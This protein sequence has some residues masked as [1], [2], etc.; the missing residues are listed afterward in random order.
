MDLALIFVAT[1]SAIFVASMFFWLHQ[2][3]EDLEDKLNEKDLEAETQA[4]LDKLDKERADR[5]NQARELI[6][7]KR[8]SA[9]S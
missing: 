7:S 8:I 1:F 6:K 5:L 2:R 3:I 4:Y 9:Q